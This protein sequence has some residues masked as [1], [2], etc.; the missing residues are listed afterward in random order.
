V[1][2]RT[3]I[4]T[5]TIAL[6]LALALPAAWSSGSVAGPRARR[7][8]TVDIEWDSGALRSALVVAP[9]WRGAVVVAS[10]GRAA[11]LEHDAGE[12]L[13]VTPQTLAPINDA[14]R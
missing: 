14:L 11:V 3:P 10:G 2:S 13:T 7:G 1:L 4:P 6:C 9:P 8:F 5:R 12:V